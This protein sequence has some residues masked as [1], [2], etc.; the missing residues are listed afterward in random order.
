MRLTKMGQ[1]TAYQLL[2]KGHLGRVPVRVLGNAWLKWNAY[3][4]W[5]L[6]RTEKAKGFIW[7]ERKGL[8]RVGQKT[9]LV[10]S[11]LPGCKPFFLWVQSERRRC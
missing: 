5:L 3:I 4:A 11:A 7:L 10:L 6:D 1:I 9:S 8:M 2:G